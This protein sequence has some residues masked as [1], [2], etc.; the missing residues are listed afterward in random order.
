MRSRVGPA[1]PCPEHGHRSTTQLERCSVRLAVD[2]EREPTEHG[3]AGADELGHDRAGELATGGGRI[4]GA[5]HRH[6]LGVL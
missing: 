6:S 5:H 3:V 1:L 2:S 4:A